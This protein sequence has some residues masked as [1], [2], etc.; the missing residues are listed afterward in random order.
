MVGDHLSVYNSRIFM[1]HLIWSLPLHLLADIVQV[2]SPILCTCSHKLVE[3]PPTPLRESLGR[4]GERERERKRGREGG[5]TISFV[6]TFMSNKSA[7]ATA[8]TVLVM[9]GW[10]VA[11]GGVWD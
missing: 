5:K 10:Y 6:N 2:V 9:R 4:K 11:S 1:D 7:L 3:V 8:C